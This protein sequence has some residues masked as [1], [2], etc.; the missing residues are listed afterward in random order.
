MRALVLCTLALLGTA[1]TADE[2][3]AQRWR[4]RGFYGGPAFTSSYSYGAPT[5][6]SGSRVAYPGTAYYYSTPVYSSSYYTYPSY[7]AYPG[8]YYGGGYYGGF[9]APGFYSRGFTANQFGVGGR[10]WWI[11]W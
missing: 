5:Y 4:S 3:Q 8:G 7:S 6:W 2:A 9:G 10:G 11:G 1:W